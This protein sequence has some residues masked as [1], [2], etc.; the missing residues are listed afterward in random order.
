MRR[1]AVAGAAVAAAV[2]AGV[3]LADGAPGLRGKGT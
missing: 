3:A 1:F 2:V